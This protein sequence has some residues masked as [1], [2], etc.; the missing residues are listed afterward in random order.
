M[1]KLMG[2]GSCR[3]GGQK[4]QLEC[5][6]GKTSLGLFTIKKYRLSHFFQEVDH[7]QSHVGVSLLSCFFSARGEGAL[8][9]L[10]GE[11]R[12]RRGR[13]EGRLIGDF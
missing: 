8:G 12:R 2:R 4:Q 5:S 10:A 1:P 11:E 7:P 13:K 6:K 9:F 3:A